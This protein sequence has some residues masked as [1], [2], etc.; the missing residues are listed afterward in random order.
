MPSQ[1]PIRAVFV[2]GGTCLIPLAAIS[3]LGLTPLSDTCAASESLKTLSSED[4][5]Q[6]KKALR[7][8]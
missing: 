3:G 4:A 6:S 5:F 1:A 8:V 7:H 2:G